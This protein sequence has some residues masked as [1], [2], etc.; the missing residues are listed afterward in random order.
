MDPAAALQRKDVLAAFPAY[1]PLL[2]GSKE[3]LQ[4]LASQP[5]VALDEDGQK[6]QTMLWNELAKFSG[7]KE[8]MLR[9]MAVRRV[10]ATCRTLVVPHAL[11]TLPVV[12]NGK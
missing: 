12:T 9:E 8:A 2:T 6:K 10:G 3:A 4:R 7:P 5:I 1:V 11:L